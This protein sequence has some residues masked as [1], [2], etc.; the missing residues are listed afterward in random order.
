[1]VEESKIS[2]KE[3]KEGQIEAH[4]KSIESEKKDIKEIKETKETKKSEI[5]KPYLIISTIVLVILDLI[6][7]TFKNLYLYSSIVAIILGIIF[8]ILTYFYVFKTLNK[9]YKKIIFIIA[10]IF[11]S[12]SIIA[13]GI[14]SI[15]IHL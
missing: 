14:Y 15:L 11:I 8:P 2:K 1:M 12:L 7:V 6:L 4:K 5:I 13:L 3:I 10:M 9:K